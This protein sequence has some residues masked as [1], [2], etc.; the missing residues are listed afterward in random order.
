MWLFRSRHYEF[1][2]LAKPQR[3]Y[4]P[5]MLSFAFPYNFVLTSSSICCNTLPSFF[6]YSNS[7]FLNIYSIV[8]SA[9]KFNAYLFIPFPHWNQ[10][11][12]DL[13]LVLAAWPLVSVLF[14]P[15]LLNFSRLNDLCGPFR[16]THVQD[17][18]WAIPNRAASFIV[19]SHFQD[20]FY[21]CL[22]HVVTLGKPVDISPPLTVKTEFVLLQSLVLFSWTGMVCLFSLRK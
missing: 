14:S 11:T 20:D 15:F 6:F 2:R 13:I 9:M 3:L 8:L 18:R 19:N 17:S 1:Q 5:M 4:I 21:I 7:F 22:Y 10:R 12:Q 16:Y